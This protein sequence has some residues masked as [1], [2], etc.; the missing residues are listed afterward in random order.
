[1][2]IKQNADYLMVNVANPTKSRA[3]TLEAMTT[4]TENFT[5]KIGQGSFGNVFLG[6]L[7]EGKQIAV[8]VLSVFSKHGVEQF[9]NEAS[10]L[11]PILKY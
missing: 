3:F 7:K 6:E 2:K 9:L 1:M 10:M 4:A 11:T 8:K 5:R